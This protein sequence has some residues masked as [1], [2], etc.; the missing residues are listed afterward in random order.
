[1]LRYHD[2]LVAAELTPDEQRAHAVL[3]HVGERHRR[4]AV[5]VL[6][7]AGTLGGRSRTLAECG[8]CRQAFIRSGVCVIRGASCVILD[9]LCSAATRLI[10]NSFRAGFEW[11][12]YAKLTHVSAS[13]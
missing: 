12:L 5:A 3:P 13:Q 1:V 6:G 4:A 10:C 7:H 11:N 2:R 9:V 8:R